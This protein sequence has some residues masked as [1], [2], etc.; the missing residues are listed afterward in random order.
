MLCRL[1]RAQGLPSLLQ[2]LTGGQKQL[3]G[4]LDMQGPTM[5]P[6]GQLCLHLQ[7][8]G[9]TDHLGDE[10]LPE[11]RSQGAC[12]QGASPSSLDIVSQTHP[13]HVPWPHL[14]SLS[15]FHLLLHCVCTV[16]VEVRDQLS[17]FSP[18]TVGSRAEPGLGSKR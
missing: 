2:S 8:P 6:L 13:V 1:G 3:W 18:T 9:S 11:E 5:A 15:G 12:L 16:P 17:Q 4:W 14:I 10:R 7:P